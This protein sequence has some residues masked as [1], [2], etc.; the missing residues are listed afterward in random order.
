MKT[1]HRYPGV[2]PFERSDQA[3]FF[4]RETDIRDLC[5]LIRVET[6]VVLFGKSGYGKSSLINAGVLP[7][8]ASVS[9]NENGG[10]AALLPVVV[11]FGD[12]V[13]GNSLTPAENLCRKIESTLRPS[14]EMDFVAQLGLP[15]SLWLT[16]KRCQAASGSESE[17]AHGNPT[18][19][20][21]FLLVFDQFEEFFSYPLDQQL[22]FRTQLAEVV[23]GEMPEDAREQARSLPR[24]QRRM[25]VSAIQVRSLFSIRS[26]RLSELDRLRDRLPDILHKRYELKA[27]SREQA[28]EAIVL[29]ARLATPPGDGFQFYS[30]PFEYGDDAL[31]K[32]LNDLSVSSTQ[33]QAGVEAFQLQ[34]LCDNIESKVVDGNIPDRDDNGLPDVNASDLPD[35][36]EVYGAYY[37]RRLAMLPENLQPAARLLIED[38]LVRIDPATGEGRR[39]SM[40]AEALLDHFSQAGATRELLKELENTFLLRRERNT[41]GGHN[42]EL[43]HDTL[44]A[45]VLRAKRLRM[46]AE[47][48]RAVN[49][50]RR[51]A[52]TLLIWGAALLLAGLGAAVWAIGMYNNAEQK[53]V[54]AEEAYQKLEKTAIQVVDAFTREA[55]NWVLKLDY[56]KASVKL[57]KAADLGQVTDEYKKTVLEVAFFYNESGQTAEAVHLLDTCAM[58]QQSMQSNNNAESIRDYIKSHD[59]AWYDSLQHRYFP[60]MKPVPGGQFV[61]N[62][63]LQTTVAAFRLAQTEVTF[64]QMKL[65]DAAKGRVRQMPVWGFSG[66]NPAVYVSW[67]EAIE[68][69][70]WLS[71][72]RGLQPVYTILPSLP[73]SVVRVNR[74]A[75]GY[76]LPT[77]REWEYAARG[78]PQQ[79]EHPYSGSSRLDD[80]AWWG[81]NSGQVHGVKRSN[82]VATKQANSL[83]LFD[84]TG[85]AWE[86][87]WDWYGA[88]PSESSTNDLGPDSG[89]ERVLRG[90]SW[91][92][93]NESYFRNTYR[94]KYPPKQGINVVG[95]RVARNTD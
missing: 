32:I 39:L 11:R 31:E 76:R 92:L 1:M 36:S 89:Q 16:L 58:L 5:D 38:G 34:I 46:Q 50:R 65:F 64:W 9:G 80:V 88:L 4:G 18:E 87:C 90:G 59:P 74:S 61:F 94:F 35:F 19:K 40:D 69:T 23:Y 71:Q 28:R 66:D 63:R 7:L 22:D 41:L 91:F 49:K 37:E 33:G 51:R 73:D 44:L 17:T 83:T 53:Q 84:M 81:S 52:V 77:E 67:F 68:Y 82:T 29:P 24:E 86:W 21:A 70:N 12:Y 95:F 25:L 78:G 85:N 15:N 30:L 13:P 20:S 6:L 27:L 79:N 45:P 47:E 54:E 2:K 26:D 42:Y 56:S 55:N 8:L 14:P 75:N 10:M 60:E 72:K 62:D 48:R 93:A 3:L 43:S 57:K